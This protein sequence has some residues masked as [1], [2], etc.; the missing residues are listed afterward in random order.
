MN[1]SYEKLFKVYFEHKYF[2]DGRFTGYKLFPTE[3][4]R[5]LMLKEGLILK[6]LPDG[7]FILFANPFEGS[8]RDRESM[9]KKNITLQFLFQID[10]PLFYEYTGNLPSS[11]DKRIFWF[12]NF[13]K[14]Q[15][16]WRDSNL[17]HLSEFVSEN[18]IELSADSLHYF[19]YIEIRFEVHLKE[20]LYIRFLNRATHWRYILMGE[21]LQKFEKLTILDKANQ[22]LF[23]GPKIIELS[24]GNKGIA[25][26]STEAIVLTQQSDKH[27]QLVVNYDEITK[28]FETELISKLPVPS[29]QNFKLNDGSIISEIFVT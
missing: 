10:D 19:G 12:S 22:K 16:V 26:T 1:V 9:L 3:Q 8:H 4:S 14:K 28:H 2:T 29:L 5:S 24:G 17:L 13:D 25:F 6:S 27:F 21:Y 23:S 7:F 18:D 15:Q 11:L 20:D